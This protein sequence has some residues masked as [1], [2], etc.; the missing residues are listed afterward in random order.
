MKKHR[1]VWGLVAVVAG[2]A[3]LLGGVATASNMGFKFVPQIPGTAGNNAFNLSLPWNNNYT[4]A[5]SLFNDLGAG[6]QKVVKFEATS[7]YTTWAGPSGGVNFPVVKGSSY[8]VFG[9]GA[10]QTPVIVGSHDPNFTFNF[11]ANQAYNAAAPYH[12]TLT[13]AKGLYNSIEASCPGSMSKLVKFGSNSKVVT[14]QG[15]S[16]GVNFNLDLGMGVIV[17]T[18]AACNGYVWPHY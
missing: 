1:T 12:Q 10:G 8:I 13:D 15:P 5:K 3:L 2:V 6:I 7:K 9:S 4:D 11:T 14:W 18:K 16:G 17:Y